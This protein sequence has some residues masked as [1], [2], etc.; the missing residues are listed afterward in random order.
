MIKRSTKTSK[1]VTTEQLAHVCGGGLA[2]IPLG[3][4]NVSGSKFVEDRTFDDELRAPKL[5]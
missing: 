3:S 4:A 2:S 5:G 1:T